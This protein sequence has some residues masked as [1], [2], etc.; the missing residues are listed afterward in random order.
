MTKA[1]EQPF[2]IRIGENVVDV[3][4]DPEA[5]G[6]SLLII[7]GEVHRADFRIAEDAPGKA[8]PIE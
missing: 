5:A 4:P 6:K 2:R 3:R 7:N 1:P 8:S